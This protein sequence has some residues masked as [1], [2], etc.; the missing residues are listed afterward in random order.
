L[1]DDKIVRELH[2]ARLSDDP[3]DCESDKSSN[4]D[5]NEDNFGPSTS[6]KSRKITRLEVSDSDVNID[7]AWN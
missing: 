6:Q 4:G 3:N 1:L 7:D 2:A 5:E